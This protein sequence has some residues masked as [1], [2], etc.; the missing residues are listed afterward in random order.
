VEWSGSAT[1]VLINGS[2]VLGKDG[3]IPTGLPEGS[4][5]WSRPNG[6]AVLRTGD[7]RLF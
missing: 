6:R 5:H 1:R 7:G 4:G 3:P 2:T